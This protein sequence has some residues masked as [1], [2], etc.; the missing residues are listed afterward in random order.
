M[1]YSVFDSRLEDKRRII[2]LGAS[3]ESSIENIIVE[4]GMAFEAIPTPC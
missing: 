4:T 2:V 1:P 3:T